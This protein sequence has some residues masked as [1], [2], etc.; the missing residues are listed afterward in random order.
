M[1]ATTDLDLHHYRRTLPGAAHVKYYGRTTLW[2]SP[3]PIPPT[4]IL[5]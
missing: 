1:A 4:R 2:K 3:C 5:L